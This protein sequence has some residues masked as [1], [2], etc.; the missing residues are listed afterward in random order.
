MVKWRR[1]L[2]FTLPRSGV[3]KVYQVLFPAREGWI[4]LEE[5]HWA[6]GFSKKLSSIAP[7]KI[8]LCRN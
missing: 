7:R 8:L 2:P 6:M 4:L 3:A 5:E 1:P